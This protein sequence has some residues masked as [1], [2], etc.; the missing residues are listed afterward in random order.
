MRHSYGMRIG[1]VKSFF[2]HFHTRI[3]SPQE[4]I[5]Q[6]CGMPLKK[7]EDFV[8]NADESKSEEFCFHCFQNDTF[9]MKE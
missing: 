9:W 3:Q 1:M 8:T 4:P 7:N 5:C 2:S 6:S